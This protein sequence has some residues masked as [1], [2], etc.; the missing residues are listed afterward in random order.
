MVGCGAGEPFP[1]NFWGSARMAWGQWIEKQGL[2]R[3]GDKCE[4]AEQIAL[5]WGAV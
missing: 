2:R 1:C 5:G 4:Q 3:G